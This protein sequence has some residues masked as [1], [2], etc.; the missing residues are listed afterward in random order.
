MQALIATLFWISLGLTLYVAVVYPC[1]LGL[2]LRLRRKFAVRESTIAGND[3]DLPTV[4]VILPAL[5]DD[6][7]LLDRL[8]NLLESDFPL[9]RMEVVVGCDPRVDL[10]ADLVT[11]ILGTQHILV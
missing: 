3:A 8:Q 7:Y 6:R 2:L 10:V 11:K 9:D 5:A 1:L 4:S